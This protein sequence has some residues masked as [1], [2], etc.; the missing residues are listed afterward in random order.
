MALLNLLLL[1]PTRDRTDAT[2][3]FS[4]IAGRVLAAGDS[5]YLPRR[6]GVN[7]RAEIP[8]RMS[9]V[10]VRSDTSIICESA[11][12]TV[13]PVR[14]DRPILLS[15]ESAVERFLVRAGT[16]GGASSDSPAAG[17]FS[18]TNSAMARC[19]FE[20][21]RVRNC[22]FGFTFG[23]VEGTSFRDC[24]LKNVGLS[25]GAHGIRFSPSGRQRVRSNA[26]VNCKFEDVGS[27]GITFDN[28]NASSSTTDAACVNNL[29]RDCWFQNQRT[30]QRGAIAVE[31][32]CEGLVVERSYFE[33]VTNGN[34]VEVLL[35]SITSPARAV[36][37]V[38]VRANVFARPWE[39]QRARLK[40][41]G[42]A[43]FVAMDNDVQTRSHSEPARHGH[44]TRC[45]GSVGSTVWLLRNLVQW[46]DDSGENARP[47][48]DIA[49]ATFDGP[50]MV[51]PENF[52]GHPGCIGMLTAT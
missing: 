40:N 48:M 42:F 49:D 31:E 12:V 34:D 50:Q 18:G 11:C 17:V 6:S 5:L 16:W 24:E 38:V 27:V 32:S 26:I 1:A 37:S 23:A 51:P 47:P 8:Y 28:R 25:T 4:E 45:E 35:R 21:L 33:R 10:A 46:H 20:G 44:F 43:S 7:R 3:D 13:E 36:R 39:G 2:F 14:S 41:E 29:V 19:L 52:E 30:P 9:E 15:A 22:G